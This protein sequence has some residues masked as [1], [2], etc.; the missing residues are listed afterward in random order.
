MFNAFT[1]KLNNNEQIKFILKDL[2]FGVIPKE[3]YDYL[4]RHIFQELLN[5]RYKIMKRIGKGAFANV[6][7]FNFYLKF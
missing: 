2:N 6:N 7:L 5:K 3:I 4:S 1:L